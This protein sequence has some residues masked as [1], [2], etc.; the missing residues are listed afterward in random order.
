MTFENDSNVSTEGQRGLLSAAAQRT[1]PDL[2]T[3][4]AQLVE[5]LER[6]EG[7]LSGQITRLIG[8]PPPAPTPP[9]KAAM[10]EPSNP[11]L[12]DLITSALNT[13]DRI[14]NELDRAE[15]MV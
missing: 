10:G 3:R 6:I 13:T 8:Y 5:M 9:G 11:P 7:R 12:T 2:H 1:R 15:G 4:M 14:Q